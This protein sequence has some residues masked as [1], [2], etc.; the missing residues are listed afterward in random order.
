MIYILLPCYNELENL[1]K[2]IKKT[3]DLSSIGL[4]KIKII[5]VNDGSFDQ[6]KNYII[7]LKKISKNKILYLEHKNNMGLN[8]ALYT[9]LIFFLKNA[10][11]KD[12]LVSLDSDNTHPISLIPRMISLIKN[13][14]YDVVIASRFQNGS[15]IQGLSYFRKI[16]SKGAR[17]LFKFYFP[18]KNVE[19][20]TCNF[21]AYKY[22]VLKKSGLIKKKFFQSKDFSIIADL[23]I[24]LDKKVKTIK[25]NE[26]PL[27]LR[28]D[29]KIGDSKLNISTN[30]IKTFLLIFRNIF[31]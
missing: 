18:I 13:D 8:V 1:K 26:V 20:Y 11:K 29:F 25:I 17:I 22:S 6:T 31:Y 21:R 12:I 24:N 16:L 23:L 9:G 27:K 10:H 14:N 3:N 5:I 30:I 28:Y 4:N 15:D 7:K 19:D 2:I